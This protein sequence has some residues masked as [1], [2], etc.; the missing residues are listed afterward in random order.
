MTGLHRLPGHRLAGGSI[1][2]RDSE[3]SDATVLQLMLAAKKPGAHACKGY[4]I[5]L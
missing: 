2:F 3:S 1:F 5:D 4:A